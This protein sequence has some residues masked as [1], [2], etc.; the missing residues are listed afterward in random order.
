MMQP[1]LQPGLKP[2]ASINGPNPAM[3]E[4][5]ENGAP[6]GSCCAMC[7]NF[8]PIEAE[9]EDEIEEIPDAD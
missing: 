9:T 7:R 8:E 6:S 1:G 5:A 3:P 4:M 2:P